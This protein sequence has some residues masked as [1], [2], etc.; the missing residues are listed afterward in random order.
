MPGGGMSRTDIRDWFQRNKRKSDIDRALGLIADAGLAERR[1]HARPG[2][3]AAELWTPSTGGG[4][5]ETAALGP[6]A[7]L[8]SQR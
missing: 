4:A 7:A 3:P 5:H 8:H 1:S 6:T 2:A